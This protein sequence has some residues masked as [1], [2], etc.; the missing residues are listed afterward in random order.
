MTDFPDRFAREMGTRAGLLAER[1]AETALDAATELALLFA[2][3]ALAEPQ[4]RGRVQ[5][6][7]ER[8]RPATGAVAA[9]LQLVPRLVGRAADAVGRAGVHAAVYALTAGEV[10][11]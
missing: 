6:L 1:V 2:E 9:A 3:R 10:K 8:A 7:L 11:R 4:L 5:P